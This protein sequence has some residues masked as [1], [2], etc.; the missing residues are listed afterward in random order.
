MRI[1]ISISHSFR[2][3]S[4]AA[5]FATRC[6]ALFAEFESLEISE[7]DTGKLK[8]GHGVASPAPITASAPAVTETA[9]QHAPA[10]EAPARRAAVWGSPLSLSRDGRE[11]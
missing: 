10:E 7:P 2:D 3:P 4:I 1:D 5:M 9:A 8:R 11:R 6:K